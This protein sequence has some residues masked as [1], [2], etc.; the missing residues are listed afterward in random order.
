MEKVDIE[1]SDS[2]ITVE[3]EKHVSNDDAAT[4]ESAQGQQA[5][6]RPKRIASFKDYVVCSKHAQGDYNF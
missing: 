6:A 5:K 1:K 2:P 3:A 4:A